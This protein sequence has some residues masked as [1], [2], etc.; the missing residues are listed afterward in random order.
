MIYLDANAT[1]HMPD[2]VVREMM[3]WI[4]CGN[5]SSGY[6]T[7]IACRAKMTQLRKLIGQ[8]C[9]ITPCCAEA[10]DGGEVSTRPDEY[11]L[12]ITSGASESNCTFIHMIVNAYSEKIGAVPHIIF[13]AIEHKSIRDCLQDLTAR[14]QIESTEVAPVR[15]GHIKPIDVMA[16]VRPN[17]IAAFVMHA[18]NETGAINDVAE[19]GRLCH[20]QNVVFFTDC[21]QTFGKFPINP[22]PHIDAFSLSF[23]KLHGMTGLGLLAIKSELWQGFNMRPV[24]YGSQN[25]HL[26]GGTENMPAI[27]AA[28]AAL[29]ITMASRAAKNK[30]LQQCRLTVLSALKESGIPLIAY[31]HYGEHSPD[32]CIVFFNGFG[33]NYLPNTIL[34]SLVKKTKPYVC[35]VEM[36][37][38]L[39]TEGII[40]SVGS[41][42]NTAS[43]K[44][45][46]VLYALGADEYIRKGTLRVSFDDC[47]TLADAK[48]FA[49]TYIK[50]ACLQ[51]RKT[52]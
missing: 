7:A 25:L 15:S 28:Y 3:K 51:L 18:N 14:G 36:K 13:S 23:H 22:F 9:K 44:A 27:A 21:V 39:E 43:E 4:N 17:T 2:E 52:A 46:H 29:K 40:V 16:A 10:R 12:I 24:I 48:T 20:L 49:D 41:A 50:I 8:L 37:N 32:I 34:L 5:P 35:N 45:S 31:E 1:T 38:R 11:K 42:C 33:A 26:R 19:I 47:N 30:A 6:K